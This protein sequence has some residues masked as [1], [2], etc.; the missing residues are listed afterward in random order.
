M[1]GDNSSGKLGEI[2]AAKYLADN[3]YTVLVC[4]YHAKNAEIDIIARDESNDTLCFIE[5]KTRKDKLHGTGSDFI[6]KSKIDKMILGARAYTV[7]QK[8]ECVVRFD[9]IEVYGRIMPSGFVV[10]EINH[11]KN[12]FDAV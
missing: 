12:A 9:V 1:K 11:I 2:Y 6:Y 4:N 8:T 10:S 3:G 7:S 5:V